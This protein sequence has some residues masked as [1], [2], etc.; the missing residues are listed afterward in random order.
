MLVFAV[1]RVLAQRRV[2]SGRS[3]PWNP[4]CVFQVLKGSLNAVV[5][6]RG[7]LFG[8]ANNR[9]H[10][11]WTDSWPTGLSLATRIKLPGHEH[12]MPSQNR[13]WRDDGSQLPQSLAVYG[14]SLHGEQSTLIVIEQQSLLSELLQ[15][16][17]DLSV[18]EFDD[19]LLTLIHHA[20]EC[21]KQDVPWL[22]Q[23]GHV[24][25][26]KSPVSGADT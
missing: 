7:I 21:S 15:Q 23:E 25:R 12:S 9:V 14:M 24:R 10:D 2:P 19:L 1:D 22:E 18:L 6:P 3:P 16:C 13:F 26:R 8:K 4:R 17:F 11:L 5:A 20:T